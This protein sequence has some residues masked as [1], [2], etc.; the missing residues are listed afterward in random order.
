[1]RV[2]RNMISKEPERHEACASPIPSECAL[3]GRIQSRGAS[4]PSGS[5]PLE[6]NTDIPNEPWAKRHSAEI[7]DNTG[8]WRSDSTGTF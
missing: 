3:L 2:K 5:L 7:W 1:M 8:D 4:L 6:L